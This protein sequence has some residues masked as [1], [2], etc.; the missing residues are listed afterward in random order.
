MPDTSVQPPYTV[1][2]L[3]FG[4][5]GNIL[6]VKRFPDGRNGDVLSDEERALWAYIQCL[7]TENLG[8]RFDAAV[9]APDESPETPP[10]LDLAPAPEEL[11]L[12]GTAPVEPKKPKKPKKP[13]A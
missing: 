3:P 8:L 7:E 10:S 4:A 2:E 1:V 13:K 12:T 9:P 11:A 6:P 5:S